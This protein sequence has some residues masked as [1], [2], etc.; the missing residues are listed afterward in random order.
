MYFYQFSNNSL[1][2]DINFCQHHSRRKLQRKLCIL[3]KWIWKK[4][5]CP[6]NEYTRNSL[7]SLLYPSLKETGKN[8]GK[9]WY[10]IHL[11]TTN[12]N[13]AY[14]E[15]CQRFFRFVTCRS[16][17]HWTW[18]WQTFIG[19]TGRSVNEQ[20]KEHLR[21]IRLSQADKSGVAQ[22]A[23]QTGHNMQLASTV[24]LMKID[25]FWQRIIRESIDTFKQWFSQ[26]GTRVSI[27]LVLES[28][29]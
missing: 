10:Q 15:T 19:Q 27:E 29:T 24:M 18:M 5:C 14:T 6:K 9:V 2:K 16:L 28:G 26:L 11:F 13:S 1:P 8:A 4:K 21:Y 25:N 23:R 20:C 3:L 17:L 7:F 12:E 22:H